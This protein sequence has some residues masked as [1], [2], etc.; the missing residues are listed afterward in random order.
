MF[1][2]TSQ[3]LTMTSRQIAELV[4]SRHDSVKRTIER[5]IEGKAFVQPPMVDE[6][7]NDSLGRPRITKVYQLDKRASL[8]VV[9]QLCP[10]FTARVVDRW[11]ELEAKAANP[12]ANLSRMDILKLAM[13]SEQARIEAEGKLAIAAPKAEAL[14]RIANADG[15]SCITDA[16]KVLQ[17]R[18][19]DL[20]KW[21]QA[22]QWIYRRQGGSGWLAYQQRIQQGY[23]EHKVTTVER[24]DGSEK[25][26]ESARVTAKGI[27]RLAVLLGGDGEAL[28]AA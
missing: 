15:S 4:D 24:G 23:M 6:Q 28:L 13:E 8:I 27:S 5:C 21:L 22:H 3:P 12:A 26:I 9:A 16:A 17:I 14:D 18:P 7:E 19:K 20:F 2:L 10:Q 11:Q 25:V 1:E